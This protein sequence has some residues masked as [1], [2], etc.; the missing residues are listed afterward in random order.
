MKGIE[1]I[2]RQLALGEFEFSRH[3]F[4]RTVERNISDVEIQEAGNGGKI[5]EAVMFR[6]NV[7][8]SAQAREESV[9]ELFVI[10]G[11]PVLVENIP[12]RVCARC[13]D[14]TFSRETTEKVRRMVHG[15]SQPLRSVRMDVFAFG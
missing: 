15:E 9:S 7:C 11:K 6:C 13:G 4:K 12:A 8:G 14:V 2:C 5:T 1:E 3:A 10:D